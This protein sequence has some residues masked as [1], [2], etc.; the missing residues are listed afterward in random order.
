[1]PLSATQ[2]ATAV[3]TIR[4]AADEYLQQPLWNF[5]PFY[6]PLILSERKRRS[7]LQGDPEQ[8]GDPDY[9]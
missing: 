3:R 1:M 9:T 4:G 8:T 7:I 2:E 5:H 6:R